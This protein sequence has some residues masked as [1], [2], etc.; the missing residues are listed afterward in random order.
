VRP[1][2]VKVVIL[3]KAFAPLPNNLRILWRIAFMGGELA[4]IC[5]FVPLVEQLGEQPE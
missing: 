2:W 3:D 1:R 4:D 5:V